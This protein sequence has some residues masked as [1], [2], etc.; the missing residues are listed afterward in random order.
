ML[1]PISDWLIYVH[2]VPSIL[3]KK[4]SHPGR[5][6]GST[7]HAHLQLDTFLVMFN[8][9]GRTAIADISIPYNLVYL[10][11]KKR[12]AKETTGKKF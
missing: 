10:T 1:L 5:Q 3:G 2:C 9:G 4:I 11:V 12:L 7:A 6:I 8:R